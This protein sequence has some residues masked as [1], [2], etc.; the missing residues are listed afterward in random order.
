MQLQNQHRAP[1]RDPR[2]L[3][4]QGFLRRPGMVGSVI[5]SSRYLERRVP[6]RRELHARGSRRSSPFC[7]R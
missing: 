5:P 1:R 3:F 7:Q 6:E 4:F 2:I